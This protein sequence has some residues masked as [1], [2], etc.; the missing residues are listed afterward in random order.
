MFHEI[1]TS[2]FISMHAVAIIMLVILQSILYNKFCII[3]YITQNGFY[4]EVDS[5]L[6]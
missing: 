3:K 2:K 5:T 6:I 4:K 1:Y